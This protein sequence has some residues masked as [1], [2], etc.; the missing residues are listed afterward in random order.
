M[1]HF[2]NVQAMEKSLDEMSEVMDCLSVHHVE[3]K[4]KMKRA[5][6]ALRTAITDALLTAGYVTYCGPLDQSLRDDLLSD[7]V[8][9]CK[10]ANVRETAVSNTSLPPESTGGDLLVPNENFS[11]QDV[12]GVAELL[13]EL[14]MSGMLSDNGSRYNAALIYSL[15]FCRSLTQSWTLFIDP[16]EQAVSCI[17]FILER[18]SKTSFAV[19]D[20]QLLHLFVPTDHVVFCISAD[21][22]LQYYL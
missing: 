9:H 21:S 3:W 6:A 5:R 13:P 12:I 18:A 14:E 2:V 22:M 17:R 11:V 15:L 7:W 16:D 10:T 1:K 4:S 20:G 8:A 19:S